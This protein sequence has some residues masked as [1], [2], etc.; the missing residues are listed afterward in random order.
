MVRCTGLAFML[1]FAAGAAFAQ[2]HEV[3]LTMGRIGGQEGLGG[4][5]ALQA[6]YGLRLWKGDRAQV[7][8]E[9]HWLAN[10]QR[11]ADFQN[12]QATSDV[13]TMYITP[14]LRFTFA[15]GS[16]VRPWVAVG[17]GWA[18]YEQSALTQSGQP[19]GAPR[20]L[21]RGAFQFGG[22][23]DWSIWRRLALRGEVRDFVT[24]AAAFNVPGFQGA[25]HNVVVGGGIVL[26]FG[27]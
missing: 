7:S 2:K 14:G 18:W 3:S 12:S 4:G 9:T 11:K 17:G 5:T 19:N 8:F 15:P 23:V 26:R 10:T 27:E 24:G 22:G 25:Q 1:F 13:A 6:N 20:N 21:Y 16:R